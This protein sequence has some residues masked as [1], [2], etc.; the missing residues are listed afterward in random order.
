MVTL[1]KMRTQFL[2]NDYFTLPPSQ[3]FLHLSVRLLQSP[4]SSTAND[5]LR[6]DSSIHVYDH[7]DTTLSIF[8]SAVISHKI[9]LQFPDFVVDTATA[10]FSKVS[11]SVR[12]YDSAYDSHNT[13]EELEA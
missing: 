12:T 6:F 13:A 4:P 10:L 1:K 2:N 8:I 7:I 3:P 11:F 9:H 5:L